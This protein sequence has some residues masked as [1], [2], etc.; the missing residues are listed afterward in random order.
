MLSYFTHLT[1]MLRS[2]AVKGIGT[3]RSEYAV[4]RKTNLSR[5]RA[6]TI[7]L[8][9]HELVVNS[10]KHA[11][12]APLGMRLRLEDRGTDLVLTYRD[13]LKQSWVAER[14]PEYKGSSG[15]GLGIIEGLLARAGGSR[16]DPGDSIHFFEACF[17]L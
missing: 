1:D 5:E 8:I 3:L 10:V 11:Q 14:A 15:L 7:G 6:T 17:P 13:R 12:G 16:L 4:D 2:M 9:V